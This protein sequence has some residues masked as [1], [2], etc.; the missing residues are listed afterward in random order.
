MRKLQNQG[1]TLVE[2]IIVLAVIGLIAAVTI[3]ALKPQEIL[4]NGRNTRRNDDVNA[5]NT[6][7]GQ[8]LAREGLQEQDPFGTLGLLELGVDAITPNDG[9]IEDEGVGSSTLTILSENY[10]LERIPMDP[11]GI[12]EY[13][14]GVDDLVNPM[15]VIVCTDKIELTD[16]YPESKYPNGLFCLS[17]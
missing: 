14:I 10:Y 12:S 16:I 4:A 8:W 3:V 9:S 1:F 2:I 13:I 15:H 5:I 17:N 11:D 7:I 6:A